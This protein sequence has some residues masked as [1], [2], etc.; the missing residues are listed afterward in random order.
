V[1]L[2]GSKTVPGFETVPVEAVPSAVLG[3]VDQC[4]PTQTVTSAACC[5][6]PLMCVVLVQVDLMQLSK[7]VCILVCVGVGYTLRLSYCTLRHLGVHIRAAFPCLC[8]FDLLRVEVG[9]AASLASQAS[10]PWLLCWTLC[11]WPVL[12]SSSCSGTTKMC[13]QLCMTAAQ[14][15]QV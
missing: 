12:C 10:D 7:C 2:Q 4:T 15:G 14:S 9:G 3:F 6:Q 8:W 5:L 13:T 1:H 11:I